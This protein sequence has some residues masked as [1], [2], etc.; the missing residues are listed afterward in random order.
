MTEPSRSREILHGFDLENFFLSYSTLFR[1]LP[2]TI[3]QKQGGYAANWS[4]ISREL[5]KKRNWQCESCGLYLSENRDLLDAHHENGN[6]AD[7]NDT[8]LKA[9]CKDCHRKQPMH[10]HMGI[11][12]EDMVTIQ[13]LRHR[14]GVLSGD[15]DLSWKDC[16]DLVDTS[17]EGLLR[18]YENDHRVPDPRK[19]DTKFWMERVLLRPRLKS[20]GPI[21]SLRSSWIKWMKMKKIIDRLWLALSNAVRSAS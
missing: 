3:L 18:L 7:N 21:R 12:S 15:H 9:L 6:K 19:S 2:S 1:T 13:R 11:S 4:E 17:F 20:L 16:I 14:Q 10:G 5:R 8:N